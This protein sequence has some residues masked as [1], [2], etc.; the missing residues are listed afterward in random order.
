MSVPGEEAPARYGDLPGVNAAALHA[1]AETLAQVDPDAVEYHA[2]MRLAEYAE[3]F[4]VDAALDSL[5]CPVLLLQADPS[6]GGRV[7]DSDVEHALSL[8][9]DGRHVRLEGV[10]HGLGLGTG[11][12]A[13]LVRAVTEFLASI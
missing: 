4:D 11:E 3:N 12:A 8:L 1:W 9:R 13:P 7:S 10:G 6:R 2:E 5:S